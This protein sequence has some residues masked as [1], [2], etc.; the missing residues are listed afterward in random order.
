MSSNAEVI[1]FTKKMEGKFVRSC[2]W[3]FQGSSLIVALPKERRTKRW[4]K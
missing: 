3:I 2:E 4:K 1:G